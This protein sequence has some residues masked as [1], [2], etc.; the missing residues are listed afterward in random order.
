VQAVMQGNDIVGSPQ[1]PQRAPQYGPES[2][3]YTTDDSGALLA[4][5]NRGTIRDTGRRGQVKAD[6]VEA[7]AAKEQGKKEQAWTLYETAMQGLKS[8]LEG[9][10]TGPLTG[11]LPA[12]T[13]PQ[14]VAEGGIAAMAPV[15]KQ[16]FR[17]AGEGV[18][19]DRDQQ[20]LLDMVPKRTDH[21]EARAAKI[22]NI[23]A[24]VKAKLG[25]D[26][27]TSGAPVPGVTKEDGYIYVGGDPANPKSWVKER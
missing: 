12:F 21:A 3:S 13:A 19:T 15:L 16:L 7:E 4:T 1:W 9:A 8:G 23:D 17:V 20:L 10:R 24:I 22:A 2:F 11:R 6:P 25:M 5:G 14:Q 27:A 18:F 26:G